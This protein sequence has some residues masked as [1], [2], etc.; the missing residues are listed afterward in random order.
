MSKRVVILGSGESG[1]GAAILAKKLGYDVFVSDKGP[2]KEV[3]QTELNDAQI[4]F[5]SGTHTVEKIT[6][7]DLII[8]SPG[9]PET[10]PLVQQLKA[11][12]VEIISEIEFGYRHSNGKII[13]ITGSNGKTTTTSLI[14][15][16]L[17]KANYD[18]AL[19]GNIGKSFARLV[20][21]TPA[22]WYVLELS[23]FQLDG[24]VD[25][26]PYISVLCNIT[27]DHLDR[28]D[29]QYE[30]YIKSKLSI[31]KNQ[32]TED[33]FIYCADDSSTKEYLNWVTSPVTKVPFTMEFEPQFGASILDKQFIIQTNQLTS[34]M[35]INEFAL[36]GIHNSYNSMAAGMAA[37]LVGVRKEAIRESLQDF[38]N[39]EHRLEYVANVNGVDYINDSKATNV[40]S[41]WYALETMNKQVV[42]IA[43]G[44]DKGNDYT[45]LKKLVEEKVKAII[46]LG[47][48]N[49]KLHKAFADVVGYIVDADNA[50]DAVMLANNI[51]ERGDAV[52]LSPACAS[53]DLFENYE[54]RGQ[55]F[56]RYVRNL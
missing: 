48:D 16:I 32:N 38:A 53:F 4:E 36:K 55:Q 28:Y 8:K 43:G 1:T 50:K 39:L 23:S 41:A 26:K 15:H 20:A 47:K 52:L 9:I 31:T 24:I 49:E 14:Y 54:D 11:Q 3:Y 46:C 44:V 30:N 33:Y 27:E 5:E 37:K 6:N 22:E 10:A 13:A 42:W 35:P 12:G 21:N 45:I 18:V 56:K 25:F 19:G 2:I 40:N 17:Q 29:Y 7:A 51:S 34:I